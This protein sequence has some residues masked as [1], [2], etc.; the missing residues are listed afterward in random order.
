MLIERHQLQ[1]ASFLPEKPI[2]IRSE[3]YPTA[4]QHS[5]LEVGFSPLFMIWMK[6]GFSRGITQ[7]ILVGDPLSQMLPKKTDIL[8]Q[9]R[10]CQLLPDFGEYI[11]QWP[12]MPARLEHAY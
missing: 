9:M 8:S 6:T 10:Q 4:S 12:H 2:R 5:G 7:T 3:F 11:S 1:K